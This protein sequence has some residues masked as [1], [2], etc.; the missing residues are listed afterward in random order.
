MTDD[1]KQRLRDH[2]GSVIKVAA[3]LARGNLLPRIDDERGWYVT[4]CKAERA[5]IIDAILE[6]DERC[7]DAAVMLRHATDAQQAEIE[8]LDARVAELTF[9]NA[10][11]RELNCHNMAGGIDAERLIR[12]RN[13]AQARV[14][15]MLAHFGLRDWNET[16]QKGWPG[17][18]EAVLQAIDEEIAAGGVPREAP[19]NVELEGGK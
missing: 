1:I 2:Y 5:R 7:K 13:A 10:A 8:R 16:L 14:R 3:D 12:D 19:I 17:S 6:A 15:W 18:D 9:N 4:T 11:L